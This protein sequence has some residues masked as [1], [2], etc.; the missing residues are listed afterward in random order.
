MAN[1]R[2]E[3]NVRSSDEPDEVF[4]RLADIPSW[5]RWGGPFVREAI[6][7]RAGA[8]DP[9]GVGAIRKVGSRPFYA[10]EEI[11]EFEPPRHMAYVLRGRA[12]LRSYRGDVDLSPAPGGGTAIRWQ[13]AVE[14]LVPGSGPAVAALFR[15][16][17]RDLAR[18]L[19]HPR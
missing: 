8:P 4:A 2:F 18:R 14:P 5:A 9:R 6:V 13:G 19:A 15:A 3:T 17:V 10:R 11:I 12:P 16:V 7:D 1:Y